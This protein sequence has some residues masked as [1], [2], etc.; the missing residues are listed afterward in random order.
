VESAIV[1]VTAPDDATNR[2]AFVML[3]AIVATLV[4]V[5]GAAGDRAVS[6][7]DE[8]AGTSRHRSET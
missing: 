8:R 1:A 4:I 3:L 6:V 2:R 5:E 7:N